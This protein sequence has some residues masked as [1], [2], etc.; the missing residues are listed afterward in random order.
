M[1][2]FLPAFE[3]AMATTDARPF[4]PGTGTRKPDFKP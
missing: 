1:E 4:P 3:A 2:Q